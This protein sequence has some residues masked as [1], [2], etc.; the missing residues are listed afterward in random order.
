MIL[1]TIIVRLLMLTF[2][3]VFVVCLQQNPKPA[4][5]TA[6][7][8]SASQPL[9]EVGKAAHIRPSPE[10]NSQLKI[11]SYN[12][13]WRG[14]DDLRRLI[15]LWHEDPEIGA[16]SLLGLQ[17]V[18]RKKSR[19]G[20]VNTIKQ[21]ADELGM[22]YAWSS[23][24]TP[25]PGDEEETG[26]AILSFFP[27]SEIQPLL[28]PHEGP[29]QRRRVALGATVA[30]GTNRLRFYSVHSE[31]RISVDHKMEQLR[32]VLED[33]DKR[34]AN[35]PAIIVGDFNTWE[36]N[37]V[38]KAH[39]LFE[40]AKFETPFNNQPTFLR[41]ILFFPLELKLD[42]IWTRNIQVIGAGIDRK[43]S[44]SDHWPLWTIVRLA[45]APGSKNEPA[46]R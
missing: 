26:V 42:W 10:T 3:F 31:T 19:T 33:L 43:I 41:K 25:I 12:I 24:P 4:R 18:D 13:R 45:T 39:K 28:L 2:L 15:K 17:E 35:M 27:L 46:Q 21:I 9:L 44:L 11:L 30:I 37:A 7:K 8:R 32:M 5:P 14:G 36:R 34:P 22:H 29:G 1:S 6:T 38:S 16:A 40:L 20:N 23:P